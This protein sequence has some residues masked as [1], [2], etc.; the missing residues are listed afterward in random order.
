MWPC[1]PDRELGV[2]VIESFW[3]RATPRGRASAWPPRCGRRRSDGAAAYADMAVPWLLETD[4]FVAALLLVH[5]SSGRAALARRRGAGRQPGSRFRHP[6]RRGGR[7]RQRDPRPRSSCWSSEPSSPDPT[8]RPRRPRA[9]SSAAGRHPRHDERGRALLRQRRGRV[10]HPLRL[11]SHLP[12]AV[13][14]PLLD[15]VRTERDRFVERYARPR[16]PSSNPQRLR[17][18]P[19]SSVG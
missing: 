2:A 15:V 14:T 11:P 5:R 6:G 10:V 7:H 8:H 16:P 19:R 18:G 1:S 12:A 3:V 17:S 9:C 13:G 4:R